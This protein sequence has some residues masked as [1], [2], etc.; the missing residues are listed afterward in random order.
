MSLTPFTDARIDW[1]G[2]APILA[3]A[4]LWAPAFL[5]GKKGKDE[6]LD[7]QRLAEITGLRFPINREE[8]R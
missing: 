1:N 8:K 6:E 5:S 2:V 4:P 3:C 7:P